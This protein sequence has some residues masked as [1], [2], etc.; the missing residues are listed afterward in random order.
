MG[1]ILNRYDP[2]H[3]CSRRSCVYRFG[4]RPDATISESFRR[5]LITSKAHMF[6]TFLADGGNDK[7]VDR[8]NPI[9]LVADKCPPTLDGG[10]RRFVMYLATEV[11]PTSVFEQF[12]MD[13]WSAPERIGQAHLVDQFPDFERRLGPAGAS[14]ISVAKTVESRRDANGRW[15]PARRSPERSQCLAQ[16]DKALKRSGNQNY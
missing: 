14:E 3:T 10:L 13:A 2:R 11:W 15:S 6:A 12:T 5:P 7:Q 9:G 1:A 4:K 16:P 8:G